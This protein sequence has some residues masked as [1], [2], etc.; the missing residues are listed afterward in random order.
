MYTIHFF[1]SSGNE[2]AV[3]YIT[4]FESQEA[5]ITVQSN[6][7]WQLIDNDSIKVLLSSDDNNLF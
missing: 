7:K 4:Q 5:P 1:V 3:N 6:G 2:P